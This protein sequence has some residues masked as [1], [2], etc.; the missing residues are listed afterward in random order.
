MG[1]LKGSRNPYKRWGPK[2]DYTHIYTY[3]YIYDEVCQNIMRSWGAKFLISSSTCRAF[4][5]LTVLPGTCWEHEN[6]LTLQEKHQKFLVRYLAK[7]L[8]GIYF[9][10]LARTCQ[11]DENSRAF[12]CSYFC[13][14][15]KIRKFLQSSI[16]C[17][18]ATLVYG[19]QCSCTTSETL[20]TC[21]KGPMKGTNL[22]HTYWLASRPAG[23]L[24]FSPCNSTFKS[25]I[26]TNL[27]YTIT[28]L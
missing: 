2:L 18:F 26:H 20:N 13:C 8:S 3:I 9:W 11:T 10:L 6:F 15:M 21:L 27:L 1:C 23:W 28:F 22:L 12:F 7:D 5:C 14:F 19:D 16:S 24:C 17:I 4:F 25:T